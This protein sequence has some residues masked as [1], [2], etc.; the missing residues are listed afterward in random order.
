MDVASVPLALS[1]IGTLLPLAYYA[2]RSCVSRVRSPTK[3]KKQVLLI[4]PGCGKS[5]LS[6]KLSHQQQYLVVDVDEVIISTCGDKEVEHLHTAQ[7]SGHDHEADLTY[8]ELALKVLEKT[9]QRM[10]ADKTLKVL[11]LTSSYRFA[12]TFKRDSVCVVAPDRESFEQ[13]IKDKPVSERERLRKLRGLFISSIPDKRAIH[14]Y[15][16]LEELEQAIRA[17]LGVAN[18]V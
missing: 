17:R 11:F 1:A 12:S 8:T 13:Y 15:K 10:K 5:W 4:P 6:D 7:N 14:T 16:T 2:G 9:K 18:L 3:I